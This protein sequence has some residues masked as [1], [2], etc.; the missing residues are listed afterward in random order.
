[1][2]FIGMQ[3]PVAAAF[4]Q[5]DG[6][7]PVYTGGMVIGKAITGNLTI[8]HN[9]N[10]LYADDTIVEDDNSITSID[11]ELGT[12]DL[13]D[14]ARQ[15]LLGMQLVGGVGYDS[16]VASGYVGVGY[17]RV[18]RL[19]G[20]TSYQGVWLYKVQ[21]SE[22]AE[23]SATKGESIEW[24]TPTLNGRAMGVDI[25]VTGVEGYVFRQKKSFETLAAAEAWLDGLAGI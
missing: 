2:A 3:H 6:A 20:V 9:D 10:P 19:R 7:A 12:D 21:F 18:R 4:S 15:L 8:N 22:N 17:I 1:M 11:L 23:N 25:A 5:A 13:S 16:D 14:E 24:Q